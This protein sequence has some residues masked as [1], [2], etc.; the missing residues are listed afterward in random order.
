MYPYTTWQEV[1]E[2]SPLFSFEDACEINERFRH[3][4]PCHYNMQ[5]PQYL[6]SAYLYHREGHLCQACQYRYGGHAVGMALANEAWGWTA[7]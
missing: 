1:L 5:S 2:A 3:L 4:L 7:Q 6:L